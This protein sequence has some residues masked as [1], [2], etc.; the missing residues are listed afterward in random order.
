MTATE[1]V[2]PMTTAE[3]RPQ[4]IWWR[5]LLR[6][7][8]AGLFA[9]P[10]RMALTILGTTIGLAALVAT[11]GLSRT[12]GNQIIA[13]FDEL[14]AT[15]ITVTSTPAAEGA[16]PNDLP[17]D[18]SER[19]GR[20]NGVVA[21]GTL[22]LV[23]VGPALVRG[24]PIKDPTRRTEFKL[25]V[26]AASPDLF[27]AVRARLRAGRFPDEWHSQQRER[28]AVLGANVAEQLGVGRL[29]Q[30]QA[31]SIGDEVFA[32]IGI[33]DRVA[34]KHGLMSEVIIP[35]GTAR[36]LY[37]VRAPQSVII[38][39][40][41]GA[42]ELL[43]RQ[44]PFALRPD[45]P[46]GLKVASPE[47]PQR[48]RAGVR[49]DLDVL[50]LMLGGVSLLVGAIGIANV[51]LVSVM[52]RVGEIGLRRAL[53]AT[54]RHIATQFLLESAAMGVLGGI[55]GAS[56]GMV[57]V[58][59]VAGYQTWAP[60]IDPVVPLLAPLIGGVTGLVAGA[61]PA[62]RAARLEPVDALRAGT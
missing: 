1:L 55:L 41:V 11:L 39:T 52:E 25:T 15:E 60:V 20:L 5:D 30:Q 24:T 54:R 7:A 27:T 59:G 28:V 6:E 4:R 56:L 16:P 29:G 13:R 45:A 62:L 18:A 57:V 10:G 46:T 8:F 32:V 9:R 47:Q 61:Y 19:V 26:E 21:A 33:I 40:Q 36:Q 50:F 37:Q 17:W 49:S 31:I 22:S 48:I 38:E 12:A 34:R 35:E 51:T 43:S 23:D 44:V 3:L 42:A 58:V 2:R 53:G 14:R